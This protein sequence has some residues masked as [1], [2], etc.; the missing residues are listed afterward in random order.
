MR[1]RME[2]LNLIKVLSLEKRSERVRRERE[3][4]FEVL[5]I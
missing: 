5:K 2:F 1:E 4:F 3:E